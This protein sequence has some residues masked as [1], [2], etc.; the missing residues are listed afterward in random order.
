MILSG[1]FIRRYYGEVVKM[2]AD[3]YDQV[4]LKRKKER[5]ARVEPPLQIVLSLLDATLR[6]ILRA[7]MNFA[8]LPAPSPP[9]SPASSTMSIE[10][11]ANTRRNP[12]ADATSMAE[13]GMS[14][15]AFAR[16]VEDELGLNLKVWD[17]TDPLIP[18]PKTVAEEKALFDQVMRTLRDRVA[19]LEEDDQFELAA[20]GL[21]GA[22]S[23]YTGPGPSSSGPSRLAHNSSDAGRDLLVQ[24][25]FGLAPNMFAPPVPK[26]GRGVVSGMGPA[27][28]S[29]PYT[30]G[31]A[32]LTPQNSIVLP[33][34]EQTPS[35]SHNR[36]Q[37][38]SETPIYSTPIQ[39]H[40]PSLPGIGGLPRRA[41]P[42]VRAGSPTRE[43]ERER[44]RSQIT[45]LG[46]IR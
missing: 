27:G 19:K 36:S 25:L 5:G 11:Y 24:E 1:H 16:R 29:G 13:R 2:I 35:Q 33:D 8:S 6:S 34:P 40:P 15:L 7:A 21:V 41:V 12:R 26:A 44:E 23:A 30:S 43:R 3:S 28:G 32:L 31:T 17:Y 9:R 20:R 10:E 4:K 46:R 14:D 39:A 45:S 38:L 42:G 18:Q 37:S 22:Q